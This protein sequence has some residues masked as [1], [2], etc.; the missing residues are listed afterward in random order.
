M[1][2]ISLFGHTHDMQ[3]FAGQGL[4]LSHSSDNI[5]SLITRL[6]R[7]SPLYLK[8]QLNRQPFG[9]MS[10][11]LFPPPPSRPP[12]L[13][14]Q[15]PRTMA[16]YW[17]CPTTGPHADHGSREQSHTVL[18]LMSLVFQKIQALGAV[19]LKLALAS[20]LIKTH[21]AGPH[22]QSSNLGDLARGWGICVF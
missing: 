4:N 18:P 16:Y 15:G 1:S 14:A 20:G 5:E 11:L 12:P 21:S 2:N 10:P 19:L 22:T 8:G 3:K 13:E 7:N 9:R 6:S 17:D